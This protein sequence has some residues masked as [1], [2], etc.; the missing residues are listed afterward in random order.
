MTNHLQSLSER[1]G[2]GMLKTEER[3][4]VAEIV[5]CAEYMLDVVFA[6]GHDAAGHDC[7]EENR[8]DLCRCRAAVKRLNKEKV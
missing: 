4:D 1:I 8:C 2:K 7:T 3:R 5:R 6:G